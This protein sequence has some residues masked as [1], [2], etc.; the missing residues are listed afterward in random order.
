MLSPYHAGSCSSALSTGSV[1]NEAALRVT[2][3]QGWPPSSFG[4]RLS[5]EAGRLEITS[6]AENHAN[7]R[8]VVS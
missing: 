2:G 8:K 1:A 5:K 7:L 6:S 4:R 3:G